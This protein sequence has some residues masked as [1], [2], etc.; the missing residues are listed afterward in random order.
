METP[1][2][3]VP[4]MTDYGSVPNTAFYHT[5]EFT[6]QVTHESLNYTMV[7][8]RE[9]GVE[10]FCFQNRDKT[11]E[12]G[13]HSTPEDAFAFCEA[14]L[15]DG[16]ADFHPVNRGMLSPRYCRALDALYSADV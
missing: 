1:T 13:W 4:L 15:A 12:Y 16:G 7:Q 10:G 9:P 5:D 2:G 6:L 11:I 8:V 3:W 14:Y